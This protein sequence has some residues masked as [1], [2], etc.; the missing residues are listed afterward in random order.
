[1]AGATPLPI[2]GAGGGFTNVGAICQNSGSCHQTQP[3][4]APS[5]AADRAFMQDI[6][7]MAGLTLAG[8]GLEVAASRFLAGAATSAVA[9][10]GTN[11]TTRVGRWMSKAEH[12][13]MLATNKMVESNLKGVS[14][15]TTP[16]NPTA[17]LRQTDGSRFVEFNVPS[18]AIR[19]KDGVT[20]KIFGPNSILGPKK[21]ITEMPPATNIQQTVSKWPRIE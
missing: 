14:S 2:R 20:G 19:A 5:T 9:A 21:G 7:V 16:P 6:M 12:Q 15:V 1:M 18:S 13:G 4:G 8:G 11:N 3:D 17:W 10:N